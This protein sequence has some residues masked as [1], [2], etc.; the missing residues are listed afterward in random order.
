MSSQ[1][2]F[3]LLADD[4]N[5][6]PTAVIARAT[7]PSFVE[8]PSSKKPNPAAATAGPPG[9]LTKPPPQPPETAK[10]VKSSDA[11]GGGRGG[12][13]SG[14]GSRVAHADRER[15]GSSREGVSQREIREGSSRDRGSFSDRNLSA[16]R[17]IND[18]VS[19]TRSGGHLAGDAAVGSVHSPAIG[20]E[21]A[22]RGNGERWALDGNR[23]RGRSGGRGRERGPGESEDRHRRREFD[24]RS[25]SGFGTEF[26]RDGSGRG[27]WG[28]E[29][30]QTS[31][32]ETVEGTGK[33]VEK[34]VVEG[35]EKVT[36]IDEMNLA[37]A[38]A[39][40]LIVKEEEDYELT[41]DEYEKI[42]EEKRKVL[43]SSRAEERK[44]LA[45]KAFESMQLVEKRNDEDVFIKVGS[46]KE[47]KKKDKDKE[48][49][50]EALEKEE[51]ARKTQSINEFLKPGDGEKFYGS[52]GS[53]G[54]G[55]GRG[56]SGDG[57]GPGGSAARGNF[58]AGLNSTRRVSAPRIEDPGQFPTLGAK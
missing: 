32:Q 23:G 31:S 11:G 3:D 4:E 5:D 57:D 45:D 6:E 34:V 41:L 37:G 29:T 52:P 40:H 22:S 27:N 55:R 1:N 51:K 35:D 9:V 48:R 21:R 10:E 12:P 53:R 13:R 8:G 38:T 47:K 24:R 39:E 28:T 56:R 30:D 16:N 14:R 15:D 36:E 50:K 20:L 46:E 44:V 2:Y 25:G 33:E 43:S 7:L 26:K 19:G 54:R 17:E 58:A 42:L 18:L 49:E